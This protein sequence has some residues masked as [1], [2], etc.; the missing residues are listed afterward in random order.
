MNAYLLVAIG[1]ALG[2]MARYGSGVLVGRLWTSSF[3][4][5]TMLINISGSIVM[6]LFI[7]YLARTT[8]AWQADARLFFAVGVLGGFTTFSTFSLDAIAMFERGE[9]VQMLT[10][11]LVSV[12]VGVAALYAGL[13]LMRG[14][15][16]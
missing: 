15:P 5:G 11:I 1:G 3:P 10:Y 9:I 4:L 12:I 13:L 7:G 8:P 16:A 2:S 14:G 6:G